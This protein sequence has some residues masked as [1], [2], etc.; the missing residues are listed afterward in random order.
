M[1]IRIQESDLLVCWLQELLPLVKLLD[2]LRALWGD[3]AFKDYMSFAPEKR[4]ADSAHKTRLYT[5]MKT[6]DWWWEIQVCLAFYVSTVSS[7]RCRPSCQTVPQL[8]Q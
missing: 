5:D 4:F 1:K 8:S 2:C 7:S 6:A 3:P